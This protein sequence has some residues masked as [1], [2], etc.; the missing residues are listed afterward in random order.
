MLKTIF[1]DLGNVLVFFSHSKMFMQ[2]A[3]CTG[4]TIDQV[5]QILFEENAQI[6]YEKGILDSAALFRIFQSRSPKSFN[7]QDLLY[8]A[9]N[10]FTPNTALWPIAEQLKQ[11]NYR[12][13]LLSNTSECHFNYVYAHYPILRLFDDRI[14]SFEVGALKP[15]SKIFFKALSQAHCNPDEC[16]YTDD[17]P[18]FVASARKV[19][20]DSEIF[21]DVPT[22]KNALVQRGISLLGF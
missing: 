1:F 22:F 14:L 21:I 18:E 6:L 11:Q 20:L 8:A 9:S 17:I 5:K 13:I 2:I 19:G 16:F 15:D 12:L 3:D 7:L 4:L 10:I